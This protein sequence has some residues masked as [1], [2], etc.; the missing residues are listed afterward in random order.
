MAKKFS[1]NAN[2]MD[3]FSK[4]EEKVEQIK[5][6]EKQLVE[7][8]IELIEIGTN[9]RNID[10]NDELDLMELGASI[11]E[12]GQLEPCIVYED[13]GKYILKVGSRRFKACLECNIPTLK[14][15]IEDPFA[16]EKDRIIKQA[17]E[18]EHRKNMS[19]R[20]REEYMSSL[21]KLGMSQGEIAKI[22]HKGKGWV[23]EALKAHDIVEKNKD[24]FGS[25]AEEPSTRDVY[26]AGN[27]QPGELEKI[28]KNAKKKGGKKGDFKEA[29]EEA[30]KGSESGYSSEEIDKKFGIDSETS[31][32]SSK[33]KVLKITFDL[34]DEKK[35]LK[36]DN[37]AL[38]TDLEKF[39][40]NQIKNYY[41]EKGYI[42]D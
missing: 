22:L 15:I 32:K 14:C 24:I 23:S 27:L 33:E 37:K 4:T 8:P 26:T 2:G 19:P 11:K 31:S 42:C 10:A 13:N 18:N 12:H 38:K 7:I 1:F 21:L 35:T 39:I 28:V 20:E 6:P 34:D 16:D 41:I 25:L 40:S 9:I 29:L 5:Y 3:A 17:I 36:L 30:K